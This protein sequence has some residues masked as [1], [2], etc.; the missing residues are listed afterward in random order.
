MELFER[1][2]TEGLYF[3]AVM[4]AFGSLVIL[5]APFQPPLSP[6]EFASASPWMRW[7]ISE[8]PE[9]NQRRGGWIIVGCAIFSAMVRLG[10]RS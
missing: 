4:I 1:F 8:D 3:P 7:L 10:T 2:A 6:E 9:R 5:R